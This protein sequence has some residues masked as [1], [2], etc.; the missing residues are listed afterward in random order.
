ML[1]LSMEAED[2]IFATSSDFLFPK[3][4]QPEDVDL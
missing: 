3:S 2:L 4:I 1:S